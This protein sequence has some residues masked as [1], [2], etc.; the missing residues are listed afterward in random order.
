[1]SLNP[2]VDLK[3][4][5]GRGECSTHQIVATFSLPK[6][7]SHKKLIFILFLRMFIQPITHKTDR[8]F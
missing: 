3:G 5:G 7:V 4:G 8:Q 2:E 6:V 1:M